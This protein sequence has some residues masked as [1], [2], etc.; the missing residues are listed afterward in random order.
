MRDLLARC[1][2]PPRQVIAIGI[3][4]PGPVDFDSGQLV[5]PPLMP[6]WDAY[7]IR[8]DLAADFSAPVFVD[9]DVNVMA[10]GELW[11]MQ[12]GLQ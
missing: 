7:S 1:G 2:V 5:N 3:G 10:L 6:Q 12:R 11:R 9:N 8:D 4:L